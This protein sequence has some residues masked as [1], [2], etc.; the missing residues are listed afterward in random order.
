MS[1]PAE[2][3][4]IAAF[5]AFCAVLVVAQE[6]W[7]RLEKEILV[8]EKGAA[9][10]LDQTAKFVLVSGADGE[11]FQFSSRGAQ[12]PLALDALI[13]TGCRYRIAYI[14]ENRY[15]I[16]A[17]DGLFITSA[18]KLDCPG[19]PEKPKRQWRAQDLLPN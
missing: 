6:W 19:A 12:T 5:L 9:N 16:D 4:K 14:D 2:L 8:V 7:V 11:T 3:L 15:W 18:E 17:G 13:T 1:R 10:H